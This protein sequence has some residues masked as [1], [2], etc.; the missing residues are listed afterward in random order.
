LVL[1]VPSEYQQGREAQEYEKRP[2][3]VRVDTSRLWEEYQAQRELYKTLRE[4]KL[5]NLAANRA[6]QIEG[7]KAAARA[8]RAV[9][10]MTLKGLEVN[11]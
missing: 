9:I 2:R 5:V 4:A 1:F 3:F 6:L 7:V 8:K 10:K 11:F